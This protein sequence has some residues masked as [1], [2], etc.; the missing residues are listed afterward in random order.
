M[1]KVLALAL[2]VIMVLGIFT[3]CGKESTDSQNKESVEIF[4]NVPLLTVDCVSNPEFE[5]SSDFIKAMWDSFAAQY[6][7]YDV[8]LKGDMVYNFQQTE[9]AANITDVY[10]TDKC[11]DISFGGYFAMSGFMY[12][13]YM[14]P[15]DDIITP[16]IYND[17][18][19]ATW[20]Q[21]RGSNG[22]TY[23][24]PY[25]ALMNILCFSKDLFRE[26]GLDEY[27]LDD[28]VIQGW[29]LDEWDHIL[30]T[31]A[32]NLPD[33]KYPMMMYAKNNQ[34]DTHTMI[35]LRCQ[36]SDFFDE[37]GLFNL[38][39]EEGIAGLQWI[40]DN[41][42]KGYYPYE[43][44]DLEIL[45]NSDM[46][47]SGQLAIYVWNSSISVNYV[48]SELG[49]VNFPGYDA[50]GVNSN[51]VT[52]FM[53]FDNGDEKK[54]E[55][56]KDF[57][58]YVYETP[59]LMDYSTSGMPCSKSVNERWADKLFLGEQLAANDVYSV[60]FTANNPNWS[61]VRNAFWPHIRAL[62]TG[63]ET[64]AEAA[65]GL[66]KDCNA[67]INSVTRTLHD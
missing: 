33:N 39:T 58:K 10:G 43:C 6:D 60:N 44:E 40:K 61:G 48:D 4:I 63:E 53:A 56:V 54:I 64:A 67:A 55:V 24:L 7:K 65:A 49:Y 32:E 37:N 8:R 57:L 66:D 47:M 22:K 26:C 59:E 11:P 51:W 2:S 50:S 5:S 20:E 41:Y 19:E 12:D 62:L 38:N 34:G 3:G 14:I 21:S 28:E 16:E 31:L 15:L 46:F 13:G 1:K 42:D 36:G 30:S 52:G 9:Y 29:S 45:D 25:Y 23:L 18:A 27:I 17:F 35:Q